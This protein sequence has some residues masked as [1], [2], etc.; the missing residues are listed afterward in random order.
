LN[1][2]IDRSIS[3]NSPIRRTPSPTK[4]HSPAKQS[5]NASPN[6]KADINL[7]QELFKNNLKEND[8]KIKI[9]D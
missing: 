4:M 7:Y 6:P 2:N 9:T 8:E 3:L 1:A 5:S